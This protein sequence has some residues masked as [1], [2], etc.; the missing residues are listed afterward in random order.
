[1]EFEPRFNGREAHLTTQS[2]CGHRTTFPLGLNLDSNSNF[3]MRIRCSSGIPGG[4]IVHWSLIPPGSSL[5]NSCPSQLPDKR[6]KIS[7]IYNLTETS[8]VPGH[9][10]GLAT[11]LC[12]IRSVRHLSTR[13]LQALCFC[14]PDIPLDSSLRKS[15]CMAD[16]RSSAIDGPN[17]RQNQSDIKR[18]IRQLWSQMESCPQNMMI[19]CKFA[20]FTPLFHSFFHD[21]MVSSRAFGFLMLCLHERRF[22]A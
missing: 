15:N 14:Q 22:G 16:L 17:I 20:V 8:V 4:T 10:L 2:A 6:R 3:N 21:F 9:G 1:M 12:G 18:N 13:R 7:E 5:E 11:F 19:V